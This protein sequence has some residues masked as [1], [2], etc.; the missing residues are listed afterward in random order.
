MGQTVPARL[1]LPPG[2]AARFP[3]VVYLHAVD[4]PQEV[5]AGL[6]AELVQRGIAVFEVHYFAPTPA[7][8]PKPG[9]Y[10]QVYLTGQDELYANAAKVW[11]RVI[12]DGIAHLR[13]Q[14]RIDGTR[15]GIAGYSLG[16]AMALASATPEAN[17]RAAVALAGF[18]T[19]EGFPRLSGLVG[20]AFITNAPTFPPALIIHGEKDGS[21][22]VAQAYAMHDGL[23]AAGR[24][25]ELYLVADADHF[26]RGKHGAQARR[27]IV[28]FFSRFLGD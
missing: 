5:P 14:P 23:R 16:A 13:T 11:P 21:A 6:F 1:C 7:P 2:E 15:I 22:P 26:W 20:E 18:I 28:E 8:G 10:L 3:A 9:S 27:R 19:L 4:G 25:A 24:T 12:A 17:V